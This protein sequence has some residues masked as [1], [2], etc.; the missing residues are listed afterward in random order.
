MLTS[1]GHL[2]YPDYGK[3]YFE[4]LTYKILATYIFE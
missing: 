3:N 4:M 2:N 1:E